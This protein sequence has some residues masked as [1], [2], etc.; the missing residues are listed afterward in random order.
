M[1]ICWIWLELPGEHGHEPA[2]AIYLRL[3]L[4]VL[5]VSEERRIVILYD[6]S[7]HLENYLKTIEILS[8]I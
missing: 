4:V 6:D 3:D 5:K 8:Y 1:I 7:D 2:N